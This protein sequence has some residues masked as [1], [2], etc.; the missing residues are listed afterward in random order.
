M[1]IF[2]LIY[3]AERSRSKY[4]IQLIR[5]F[6]FWTSIK[7]S[8]KYFWLEFLFQATLLAYYEFNAMIT[9]F[10]NI[11][12]RSYVL[13]T[14]DKL[15]NNNQEHYSNNLNENIYVFP[16]KWLPLKL[17][18]RGNF[19]YYIPSALNP[20]I[21]TFSK[22]LWNEYIKKIRMENMCVFLYWFYS[23]AKC[24]MMMLATF[25]IRYIECYL[26]F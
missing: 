2:L 26:K 20:V 1:N 8:Y 3:N 5:V 13:V 12:F 14:I 10:L 24:K 16:R 18:A 25:E 22:Y 6:W 7:H 23:L 21:T 19:A 11:N 15:A 4:E 17:F 9:F